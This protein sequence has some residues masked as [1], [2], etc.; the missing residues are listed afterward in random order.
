MSSAAL[1]DFQ[2][3]G[4]KWLVRA[5]LSIKFFA[6]RFRNSIGERNPLQL[7]ELSR[8]SMRLGAFDV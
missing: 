6:E 8:Q 3:F 5:L 7:G 4:A 1:S 2:Q